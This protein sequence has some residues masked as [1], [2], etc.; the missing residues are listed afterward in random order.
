MIF[1]ALKMDR[2]RNSRLSPLY[3][4]RNT[5]SVKLHFSNFYISLRSQI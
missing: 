3:L 1:Q 2:G 4:V 5:E